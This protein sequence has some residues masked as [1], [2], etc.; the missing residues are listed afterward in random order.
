MGAIKVGEVFNPYR[1]LYGC[2]IPNCLLKYKGLTHA[3][4][5]CWGR[6]A[7]FAGKDGMAYPSQ[8]TLAEEICVSHRQVDRILKS[9]EEKKFIKRV[10]LP[11][12]NTLLYQFLWHPIFSG[13]T[14]QDISTKEHSD[15]INSAAKKDK[16]VTKKSEEHTAL[17]SYPIRHPCRTAYDT[18][19]VPPTTPTSYAYDTHVVPP[20]TPMSYEYNHIRESLKESPNILLLGN[21]TEK[22]NTGDQLNKE[23][24]MGESVEINTKYL[25]LILDKW[26]SFRGAV[27]PAPDDITFFTTTARQD[28][29]PAIKGIH[30]DKVLAA[31]DNFGKIIS[32]QSG[33]YFWNR[34]ISIG[35]FF[36]RHLTDFLPENFSEEKY[37]RWE[38]K[39][40]IRNEIAQ[41]AQAERMQKIKEQQEKEREEYLRE[42]KERKLEAERKRK[43][44]EEFEKTPE[45]QDYLDRCRSGW[46][47]MATR[48]GC[49]IDHDTKIIQGDMYVPRS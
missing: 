36:A 39:E 29:L 26:Q 21:S 33:R 46:L 32:D 28:I 13:N 48:L 12:R 6:L 14:M 40:K 30:S 43:E 23:E 18:H 9:L 17:T 38:E 34:R 49:K 3:E 31:L 20:T 11:G 1:M 22:T 37:L 41:K 7:Q 10:K 35:R 8:G 4:K 24:Q 27:L 42:E 45:Y 16:E 19:V 5:F 15:R 47:R 44:Q 2:Y 25:R